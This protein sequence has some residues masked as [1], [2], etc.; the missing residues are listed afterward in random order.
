MVRTIQINNQ[1]IKLNQQ[2]VLGV[3]GEAT[4]V[5]I[6][7]QLAV[8][9]YH[10]P[11][12]AR[13][14]KLTDFINAGMTLPSQ[15]CA[16]QDLAYD[17]Q[18]RKVLG[19]SMR[20]IPKAFEVVQKLSSK[21]FRRASP[22]FNGQYITDVFI[23]AYATTQILHQQKLIVGDYN[24]LNV[25]FGLTTPRMIFLDV[26]SFQF[27]KHPC[28]VGT[29]NFLPP[30]L[31]NIDLSEKP[32]F[33]PIHDWYAFW[34][35]YIRSLL[36]V[37]PYGG[38]HP[39]YKSLQ[40]RALA[41]VTVF[42]DRVKYPKVGFSPGLLNGTLMQITD[43]FFK[44]GHRATPPIE[45]LQE[46]RDSLVECRS[47]GVMHPAERASCPQCATINM[48]QIHRKVKIIKAPGKRDVERE[49]ILST[50][51]GHF[52]WYKV[53]GK[54]IF[55]IAREGVEYV[56]Y[57]KTRSGVRGEVLFPAGKN[58]RP[59][60]DI[61]SGRYLVVSREPEDQMV[62]I[63][64]LKD[65]VNR[66]ESRATDEFYGRRIFACTEDHLYRLQ[67][68]ILYRGKM[69]SIGL[70][71]EEKVTTCIRNQTWFSAS[72]NGDSIF[73]CQRFFNE[74]KFFLHRFD[75]KKTGEYFDVKLE[76]FVE[77]ATILDVSVRFTASHVLFLVKTE[78]NG[79]TYT[80][81]FVISQDN[82]KVISHYC[83]EAMP[84]DTHRHIHG[85]A[86]AKPTGTNGMILHATD[87]GIVQGIVG[88]NQI[89]REMLIPEAE[90]FVREEDSLV[91]YDKGILVVGDKDIAYL[92][93][94]NG[95]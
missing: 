77:E 93:I 19:F 16:P 11:S 70:Y 3:G 64:D 51:T 9:L 80:D 32:Y 43:S 66:I 1:R 35:M 76:G 69:L 41:K 37:H 40:Q 58:D 21:K 62:Q 22:Q 18:G 92:T 95:K 72:P 85:K 10:K 59:K 25:M 61:F 68:G 31:Y 52:V 47:C 71:V 57:Y 38:F 7:K 5:Q 33:D 2:D 24:D 50:S 42:D 67:Q 60:F 14:N 29:E 53:C 6:G 15:V 46:Y 8:K 81:V 54:N 28:M 87:E 91:H 49:E 48:V 65:G 34:C 55:A 94:K 17:S 26:D 79:R 63:Y 44:Q 83:V 89:D 86:F 56:L 90:Q 39:D 73:G 45:A 23:D 12:S 13:S 88:D 36:M 74:M 75:R 4:V 30:E 82:G 20:K 84:S 27:G 78:R